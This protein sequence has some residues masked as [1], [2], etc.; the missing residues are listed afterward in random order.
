MVGAGIPPEVGSSLAE[1][2]GA[3]PAATADRPAGAARPA[4]PARSWRRDIPASG[5]DGLLM[6]RPPGYAFLSV[7]GGHWRGRT[8]PNRLWRGG[9]ARRAARKDYR[10]E[11]KVFQVF[12]D[13]LDGHRPL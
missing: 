4:A 11:L 5:S 9:A 2:W 8:R 3:S 13:E 12:V 10:L 6:G 1:V 7:A